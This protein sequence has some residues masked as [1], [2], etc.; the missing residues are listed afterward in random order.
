MENSQEYEGAKNLATIKELNDRLTALIST[1]RKFT[2]QTN[3]E[4]RKLVCE[5]VRETRRMINR[6]Y[7]S[8]RGL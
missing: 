2:Y 6:M 7:I 4:E 5:Q 3:P 1:Q 8:T